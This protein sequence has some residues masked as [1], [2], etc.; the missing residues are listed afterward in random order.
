MAN[1]LLGLKIKEI[2]TSVWMH[3]LIPIAMCSVGI[4]YCARFFPTAGKNKIVLSE[5]ILTSGFFMAISMGIYAYTTGLYT[6]T[7]N[8]LPKMFA[9]KLPASI[10]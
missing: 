2:F 3:A 1:K 8:V 10:S 7:K 5:I 6:I 9:K 4:F